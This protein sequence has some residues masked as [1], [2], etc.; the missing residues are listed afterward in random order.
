MDTRDE[1]YS[2]DSVDEGDE[3]DFDVCGGISLENRFV[4]SNKGE[5]GGKWQTVAKKIKK[6]SSSN[7]D[8]FANLSTD[9]KLNCIFAQV[10]KNFEKINDV[11]DE[12]HACRKDVKNVHRFCTELENRIIDMERMC[13]R[14]EHMSKVLCYRS[15]DIEARSMRN[16]LVF[17]GI[18]ERLSYKYGDKQLILN[19]LQ[20][21]LDIDTDEIC[22][23]R[24]HRLG[25][26]SP[27]AY[28]VGTDQK[29]PLI[30]RFRDYCD[31]EIIMRK[32]YLLKNS[33]FGIDRQ[34]PKEMANARATLY[35]SEEAVNARANGRKVQIPGQIIYRQQHA[36]YANTSLTDGTSLTE[37]NKSHAREVS[38]SAF[39]Y[40]CSV[41]L[42]FKHRTLF[43]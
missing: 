16:N 33:R 8:S 21:E 32:V 15:I 1:E 42:V 27:Q 34:Y 19:F 2:G 14:Q 31:T 26:S 43:G 20:N 40:L 29:R 13:V 23:E 11:E 38:S 6:A 24:A 7:S 9:E 25:K 36:G 12:Q 5:N 41:Y 4:I 30:A 22:I 37:N 35:K 28:R 3:G 17:Y 10:N 39:L 18:T